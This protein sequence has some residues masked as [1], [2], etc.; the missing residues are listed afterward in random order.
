[1]DCIYNGFGQLLL[2]PI[3]L[4]SYAFEI[5]EGEREREIKGEPIAFKQILFYN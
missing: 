1:M 2:L 5:E 4:F 3:G